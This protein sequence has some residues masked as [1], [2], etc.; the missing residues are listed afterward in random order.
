VD[1]HGPLGGIIL[2]ARIEAGDGQ[3]A[4][5]ASRLST[6]DGWQVLE[7]TL[8]S[9]HQAGVRDPVLV[10]TADGALD[11]PGGQ[12]LRRVQLN[13]RGL[14]EQLVELLE[15]PVPGVFLTYSNTLFRPHIGSELVRVEADVALAVDTD[16]RRRY[17]RANQ[18]QRMRAE[19]VSLDRMQ[20]RQIGCLLDD[21]LCDAEFAGLAYAS[22]R[23]IEML[24]DAWPSVCAHYRERP[25][26]DAL[27]LAEANVT[28]LIQ[29]LIERGARVVGVDV[30]R[31]WADIKGSADLSRF[32]YGTKAETLER[33]KSVVLDTQIA[34]LIHF[35]VGRWVEQRDRLIELIGRRFQ[36]QRIVVRS[37]SLVEDS[38]TESLAGEFQS[39]LGVDAEDA[40]AVAAAVDRVI[41]SY[42]RSEKANDDG[43]H[44]H[45]VLVQVFLEQ[46]TISGV[47]F[48][49]DLGTGAPYFV[50]N[51]DDQSGATDSVTGGAGQNL[52]TLA[53]A[54]S[55]RGELAPSELANVI[56]AARELERITGC[57]SLDIEFATTA[58]GKVHLFQVRPLA[59]AC[60]WPPL[61][62]QAFSAMIAR[63]RD[64]VAQ[65]VGPATPRTILSNMTDWNPA[66]MI[67]TAPSPLASTLYEYLVTDS[68]WRRARAAIGYHAVPGEKLM[69]SVCGMPY[70]DVRNSFR[71]FVPAAVP[72]ELRERLVD[73]WLDRLD[74]HP[75]LHDKAEF[76][77]VPT[78]LTFDF[79]RDAARL[80]DQGFSAAEIETLR[81]ALLALTDDILHERPRAIADAMSAVRA[82]APRADA[83]TVA[84]PTVQAVRALLVDCREHGVLPFSILARYAFIGTALLRSLVGRGVLSR[85]Q[86]DAITRGVHTLATDMVADLLRTQ[87]GELA[88]DAFLGR[89]GHLRPGTYDITSRRYDEAP[90]LYLGMREQGCE[91]AAPIVPFELSTAQREEVRR[92][93]HQAGF[94]VTPERLMDFIVSAIRGR[95]D[96]KFAFSRNV[97]EALRLL[98][99]IGEQYGIERSDMGYVNVHELLW[100]ADR[101]DGD[102]LDRVLRTRIDE[103][104]GRAA[105]TAAVHLPDVIRHADDLDVIQQFRARPNFVTQKK[106]TAQT[107]CLDDGMHADLSGRIVLI[108][109]A[110]PGFDWVFSRKVAGLITMFGGANSHMAIRCAEF[111]IPAAIG[112]GSVLYEAARLARTVELDCA[113]GV[114]RAG[115]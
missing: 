107:V 12:R 14:L 114:L 88:E 78:C 112:C 71:S 2:D 87:K 68:T 75:E 90:E 42:R 108:Q 49:R 54:K 70:I 96:A 20:V 32:V 47:A 66:E 39:V 65:R 15:R 3:A 110:D 28:D 13:G 76:E 36:G 51:Y 115:V 5:F 1:G 55:C 100:W 82:L 84:P 105:V 6:P 52:K 17:E 98:C 40:T 72:L 50:L 81:A 33:L 109:S 93:L 43:L 22:R 35:E 102:D 21:A 58:D 77:I 41:D 63:A 91:P 83:V 8:Y 57:D 23:G 62:P 18:L 85:A 11:V 99:R 34:D 113:G 59:T 24:R 44:K 97:S 38:W 67:S 25:F 94:T 104:K 48:T 45:Q 27:T 16:W 53:L 106:V 4:R 56:R 89:Y 64:F 92:L 30:S 80:A 74:R 103:A 86:A 60:K 101:S 9:L 26:H 31:D 95:E 29:E 37:S 61:D 111:A 19:K 79:D 69:V 10:C 7:W 73:G 46:V